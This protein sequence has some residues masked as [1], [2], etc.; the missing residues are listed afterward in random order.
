MHR[1]SSNVAR[2]SVV[3]AIALV[4]CVGR[5]RPEYASNFAGIRLTEGS[6]VDRSTGEPYSGRLVARNDEINT[7]GCWVLDDTPLHQACHADAAGMIFDAK[8]EQGQL[9]GDASIRVDLDS[10]RYGPAVEELLGDLSGLAREVVPTV[11]VAQASFVQGRLEGTIQIFEPSVDPTAS[12]LL[13][14]ATFVDNRIDGVVRE[15]TPGTGKPMRELHFDGGVRSGPQRRFFA[16][17]SL[18]EEVPFVD[19]AP[20]GEAIA[21]YA[22]RAQRRRET[23]KAGKRVGVTEAWY[24]DGTLRSREA[25]DGS[26]PR[27][28]R[29]YS[30]GALAMEAIGDEVREIPPH[31]TVVEYY[32]TGQ[33][34]TKA[35]F[36]HGVPNG[37]FERRYRDGGRW[38]Q[39]HAVAGKPHGVH[40]KWWKNGQKALEAKYVDGKLEGPYVRWYANGKTWE[41]AT[42]RNDKRVGEYRKWWKNGAL[43]HEYRYVDGKLDGEYRTYYDSGAA[44]AV[45]EYRKGKPIGVHRRWFPDGLEG[46]VKHHENGRP[47][48][49]FKRWW[50]DGSLRLDSTYVKGKLHGAYRN[51]LEDGSVYEAATYDNGTKIVEDGS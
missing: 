16:D 6:I 45:A 51:W 1:W 3:G 46:Y 24:P 43:A 40:Q 13:A 25:F 32:D 23:W 44:W 31:G 48:G 38:E 15:Y 26:S 37:A 5:T 47:H 9:V 22:N 29:W 8:V 33:L 17:G 49:A 7:I 18:A 41:K 2:A 11:E 28:Q 27:L 14:E 35:H 20:D 39:S 30:N 19:G 34:E 4:A 50:A 12:T 42:Y 21:Y 36:E 10:D